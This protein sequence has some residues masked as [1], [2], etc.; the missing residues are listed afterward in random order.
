MDAFL[1]GDPLSAQRDLST[2]TRAGNP[3]GAA[4]PNPP[5]RV[6]RCA[7]DRRLARLNHRGWTIVCASPRR[8]AERSPTIFR[9]KRGI[10]ERAAKNKEAAIAPGVAALAERGRRG[11]R[12]RLQFDRVVLWR[13]C[14]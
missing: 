13:T 6:A 14:L 4:P 11:P 1:A 5:I 3:S 9:A 10:P 2:P 12:P 7:L 8:T